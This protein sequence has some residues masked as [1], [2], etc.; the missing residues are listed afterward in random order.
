VKAWRIR[1]DPT[2]QKA[3]GVG[4]NKT[5]CNGSRAAVVRLHVIRIPCG[6]AGYRAVN[7]DDLKV[8]SAVVVGIFVVWTCVNQKQKTVLQGLFFGQQDERW[9]A[10]RKIA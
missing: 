6:E 10:L 7:A 3:A 5:D 8:K 4:R 2:G 1:E 9:D